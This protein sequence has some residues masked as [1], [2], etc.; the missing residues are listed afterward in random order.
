MR[1]LAGWIAAGALL[2]TGCGGQTDATE[3]PKTPETTAS[4]PSEPQDESGARAAAEEIAAR[5]AAQDYTGTWDMFDAASQQVIPRDGYAEYGEVCDLGG[6]PLEVTNVRLEDESTA[7]VRVGVGGFES[8]LTFVYE[9]GQWRQR[10]SDETKAFFADGGGA[11]DGITPE[12][13]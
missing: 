9:D 8:A 5:F 7:V 11:A 10:A 13:C 6:L 2:L 3:A 12:D 1:V 4:E